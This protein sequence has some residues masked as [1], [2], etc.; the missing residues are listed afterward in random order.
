[1]DPLWEMFLTLAD[2]P[3]IPFGRGDLAKLTLHAEDQKG[4]G[5]DPDAHPG[6]ALPHPLDCIRGDIH[7]LSH[8]THRDPAPPPRPGNVLAK[9]TQCTLGRRVEALVGAGSASHWL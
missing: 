9:C 4:G 8:G 2:A 5:D 3:T 1:M 7:P 6:I